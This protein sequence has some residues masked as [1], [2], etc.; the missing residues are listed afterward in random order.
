MDKT[1]TEPERIQPRISVGIGVGQVLEGITE[2]KVGFG[3]DLGL[4]ANPGVDHEIF[5]GSIYGESFFKK[6]RFAQFEHPIGTY[7]LAITPLPAKP[8]RSNLDPWI[9]FA[10]RSQCVTI[11]IR[12]HRL[13]NQNQWKRFK[14][15]RQPRMKKIGNCFPE[16]AHERT[17]SIRAMSVVFDATVIDL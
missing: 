10:R 9:P 11:D 13:P 2:A 15:V 5:V 16:S 7:G 3:M 4:K 12:H 1:E 6:N 14:D 17:V 8:K